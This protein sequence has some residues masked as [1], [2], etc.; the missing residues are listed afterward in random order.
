V[1]TLEHI[2]QAHERIRPYV[3]QTPV[4]T[5]QAIN[6]MVDADL[7]FKCENLQKVGAFKARGAMNAV[8]LLDDDTARRGVVTHSSGNHAQALAYAAKLRSIPCTIVM[9]N[10][11]PAVKQDAVRE[12][13]AEV[14]LCEAT[15]AS[16]LA[17]ME[18]I[19]QT[20]GAHPVPPYNDERVIAGQGTLALELLEQVPSLE[21][22]MA[23]IGGGGLMSGIATAVRGMRPDTRIIGAEPEIAAD[24]LESMHT[25]VLQPPANTLTIADGLRTGLGE[26]TFAHL[27]AT[28]VEILTASEEAIREATYRIMERL[29]VVIEP[30]AAVTLAVLLEH[31][32]IVRGRTVGIVLCGGNIDIRRLAI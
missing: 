15:L 12:Y 30:S 3:H 23:P 24:A 4:L 8:L 11:A 28:D 25:G 27:Q 16:R 32:G 19:V 21:V 10:N 18:Q 20:T 5:S 17:T 2:R 14:V 1:V 7:H 22:V 26:I 31:P 9:P 6:R 13:G 29:K